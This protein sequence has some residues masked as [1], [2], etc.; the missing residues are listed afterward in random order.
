VPSGREDRA[1]SNQELEFIMA[2]PIA[3]TPRCKSLDPVM[4]IP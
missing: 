1:S 3:G 2:N 4:T